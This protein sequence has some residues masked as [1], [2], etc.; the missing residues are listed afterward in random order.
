MENEIKEKLQ[1][2]KAI[3]TA[4][5]QKANL[6]EPR[7]MTE[8]EII[9]QKELSENFT[10]LLK[11][12]IKNTEIGIIPA[13][14]SLT[15]IQIDLDTYYSKVNPAEKIGY[16]NIATTIDLIEFLTE[17]NWNEFLNDTYRQKK[18]PIKHGLPTIDSTKFDAKWIFETYNNV[19]FKCSE[20]CFNA[21]LV[22]GIQHPETINFILIGR[23]SA[24]TKT[25]TL[26]F[27]QLRKFIETITGDAENTK[28]AYYKTVFGLKIKTAQIETATNLNDTFK[29]L[30]K[31]IVELKGIK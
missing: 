31:K 5:N 7:K 2:L 6:P 20:E 19:V 9:E 8:Q 24:K 28:D 10:L 25:K 4:L 22:D 13:H 30:K 17:S 16:I 27:A 15:D 14:C 21:W 12:L 3:K 1:R 23:I 18:P 26:Q 29:D 11:D